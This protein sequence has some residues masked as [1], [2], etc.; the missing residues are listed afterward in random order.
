MADHGMEQNDP[1]CRGDWDVALREAGIQA[2]D[3]AY[4]FLYFGVPGY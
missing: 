2:R 4:G 1:G 3:E